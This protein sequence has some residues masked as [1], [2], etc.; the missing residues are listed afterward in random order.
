MTTTTMTPAVNGS[1]TTSSSNESSLSGG[2]LQLKKIV[3]LGATSGIALEVQRL[4]AAQG[5]ELL[6]IGRSGERLAELQADLIDSRGAAGFD[7]RGRLSVDPAACG[8]FR[9][10]P[11]ALPRL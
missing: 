3:V 4:L 8:Y 7:L 10:R 5:C 6:L 9:I 2:A 11:A 1:P